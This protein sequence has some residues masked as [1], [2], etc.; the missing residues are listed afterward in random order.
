MNIRTMAS[1]KPAE[2]A[3]AEEAAAEVGAEAEEVTL[4]ECPLNLSPR[5][6]FGE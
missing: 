6:K 1:T 5:S 2:E 4:A 3:A